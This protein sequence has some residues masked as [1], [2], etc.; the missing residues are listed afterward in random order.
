[1]RAQFNRGSPLAV[2]AAFALLLVVPA[3]RAVGPA[4]KGRM[5]TDGNRIVDAAGKPVALNGIS[6]FGFETTNRVPHG[7]WQRG[8]DGFLD[9]MRD[10]GYNLLRAP[11]SDDIFKPDAKT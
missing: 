6:W 2:I 7:L 10:L 4:S 1:M 3:A 5:H 11:Y 9:Q 8:M